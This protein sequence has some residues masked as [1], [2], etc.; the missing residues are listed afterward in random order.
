MDLK[1][2]YLILSLCCPLHKDIGLFY[3]VSYWV[4]SSSFCSNAIRERFVE[5]KQI[6]IDPSRQENKINTRMEEEG[7]DG[8]THIHTKEFFFLPPFVFVYVCGCRA[9]KERNQEPFLSFFFLLFNNYHHFSLSLSLIPPSSFFYS[10][11]IYYIIIF[12][13]IINEDEK[14]NQTNQVFFVLFLLFPYTHTKKN[15]E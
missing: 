13:I 12:I 1:P 11:F 5:W 6:R 2:C 7:E 9:A 3:F 14:E 15:P 4:F 10:S 8:I